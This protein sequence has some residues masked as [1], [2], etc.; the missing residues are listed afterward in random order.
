M[1][2]IV[3][4]TALVVLFFGM[5]SCSY[6][7]SI[8]DADGEA[9]YG[10][11]A[12][13]A[14]V[15]LGGFEQWLVIR[16]VDRRNPILLFIHG[17]PGVPETPLF[18]SV[19]KDLQ[20]DFVVVTWDQRGT[21]LSFSKD[22]PTETMNVEQFIT[23]AHELVGYLKDRFGAE[24]IYI[25]GHSW[26]SVLGMYLIDRYPEDFY[27]YVGIGQVVNTYENERLS[28]EYA[29]TRAVEEGNRKAIG[30]LEE[31]G[32]PVN[33]V[34]GDDP[35][36]LDGLMTQRKWLLKYNGVMHEESSHLKYYFAYVL[37]PEYSIFDAVNVLRGVNYSLDLM[38]NQ[39]LQV[40]FFTEI[41]Q[42]QVPVY[43]FVGRYDYNTPFELVEKYFD[44][45]DAQKKELVWFEE[46][47]HMIS[48]E[49]PER[50][51]RLMVDK[52]LRE[53]YPKFP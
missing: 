3:V 2:R 12:E 6:T 51:T 26:G 29:Y 10:S 47:A 5:I 41:T 21:G 8:V 22:V 52:V 33:G 30:E 18:M 40:D 39:V 4:L 1:K 11:I 17:G 28:F 15:T 44:V 24:K 34:Y 45:L 32:P 36:D 20:D 16:G 43:F 49:E 27:A 23:D 13:M 31:I 42:V 53:T 38:W 25:V 14:P 48:S 7:P 35:S 19:C 46:S 37:S 50:F 9:V